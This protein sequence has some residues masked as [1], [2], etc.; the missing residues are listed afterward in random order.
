MAD[1]TTPS[2]TPTQIIS[3]QFLTSAEDA[4]AKVD[5]L[6]TA[7]GDFYNGM[8]NTVE[9]SEKQ[10]RTIENLSLLISKVTERFT[11]LPNA[12]KEAFKGYSGDIE[13]F[14]DR[15]G[16]A[17]NSAIKLLQSQAKLADNA[18]RL[19]VGYIGLASSTGDLGKVFQSAGKNLENMGAL[20]EAQG[21]SLLATSQA[22]GV[23][24]SEVEKYY[25]SL[26]KVPG[27]MNAVVRSSADGR[28]TTNML[29]AAIKAAHGTGQSFETVLGDISKAYETYG[30]K[31]EDALIFSTR[32]YDVSDKLGAKLETVR[33]ELGNVAAA[34]GGVVDTGTAAN[35]MAEG[36]AEIMS[37][38]SAALKD[39]GI[40]ADRAAGI[41][42][43]FEV[44]L[45]SL[46][47]A[48]R[49]FLSQ[50]AGGPGGL[51]GAAQVQTM[52]REGK[53]EDVE[54]M[55]RT[56]L[57]RQFGGKI[58]TL[59][60]AGQSQLAADI[61]QK[62][63]QILMGGAFGQLAKTE[64]EAN[65]LLESFKSGGLSKKAQ[66]PRPEE[67]VTEAMT[68]GEQIEKQTTTDFTELRNFFEESDFKA[69]MTSLKM[70]QRGAGGQVIFGNELN[71]AQ[72]K[73]TQAIENR[74][75]TGTAR[76]G[77]I[78]QKLTE[79][80]GIQENP[81]AMENFRKDMVS[82]AI[83]SMKEKVGI[84]KSAPN[85][86]TTMATELTNQLNGKDDTNQLQQADVIQGARELVSMQ[87]KNKEEAATI[88][89]IQRAKKQQ[90]A[91]ASAYNNLLPTEQLTELAEQAVAGG[92]EKA[93]Q[94]K[95]PG[96]AAYAQQTQQQKEKYNLEVTAICYG[97]QTKLKTGHL[98]G[99][100]PGAGRK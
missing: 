66:L 5:K 41:A 98:E 42:A 26:G 48:E 36:A 37:R 2:T 100:A 77:R 60:E 11:S 95:T 53:I 90:T 47:V 25:G 84:V 3:D 57:E 61:N 78:S 73:R 50:Q 69:A 65:R 27:A 70:L 85:T 9:I 45:K 35:R 94:A 34:F 88:L 52:L 49:A 15:L 32:M 20:V 19:Q 23:S 89:N 74:I 38:Y 63:V 99:T 96:T 56:A 92:A 44:Q 7:L 16:I 83:A 46:G 80:V 64:D 86:F 62:Q 58:S 71:E 91:G 55:V 82:E 59:Q 33:K 8:S 43:N 12:G 4:R 30:L 39:T 24:I 54:K 75:R 76:G 22:T 79:T 14:A 93:A 28:E 31:G 13:V 68:R 10:I 97:C 51:M 1:G 18:M 6:V 67:T 40:S 87:A 21:Q 81:E 17:D 29:T 72:D